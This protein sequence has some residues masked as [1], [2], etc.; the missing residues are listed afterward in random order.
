MMHAVRI[1]DIPFGTIDWSS[2]SQTEHPGASGLAR[3][4]T[5]TCGAIRIRMV[6]NT[7]GYDSDSGYTTKN[8]NYQKETIHA[9]IENRPGV[10]ANYGTGGG[11][12]EK[13]IREILDEKLKN[14]PTPKYP[15][16]FN[17]SVFQQGIES[18]RSA[19]QAIDIPE[20]KETDLSGVLS[21]ITTLKKAIEGPPCSEATQL[22]TA[23]GQFADYVNTKFDEL[24]EKAEEMN[25][26]VE[27]SGNDLSGKTEEVKQITENMKMIGEQHHS[28]VP[29]E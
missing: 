1:T 10:F 2:V 8:A 23:L 29:R 14:I 11:I 4:R 26:I 9:V 25:S 7:P 22:R 19:I 21:E 12:S 27:H 13:K 18:V 20:S 28:S 15:E 3:W 6:D 24:R 17:Y 16:R 5:V